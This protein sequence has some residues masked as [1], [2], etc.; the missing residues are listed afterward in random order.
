LLEALS[1]ISRVQT[2]SGPLQSYLMLSELDARRPAD[3][4]LRPETVAMLAAKFSDFGDQ[5]LIFSEFPDLNDASIVVFLQT[6]PASTAFPKTSCVATLLE[7]S[8][9]AS[10]SGRY[11]R[12]KVKSHRPL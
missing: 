4:R 11:S 2:E 12:V 3:R 1:A 8:K 10:D 9:P 6:L 7:P 5:Y